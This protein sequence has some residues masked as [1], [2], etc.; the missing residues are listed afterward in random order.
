MDQG[1]MRAT[2][3]LLLSTEESLRIQQSLQ[4]IDAVLAKL[5][6]APGRRRLRH[7]AENQLRSLRWKLE[8]CEARMT[9]SQRTNLAD[10]KA[11]H[12]LS[13]LMVS[14]ISQPGVA[15]L[16]AMRQLIKATLA[17]RAKLLFALRVLQDHYDANEEYSIW[18]CAVL[19]C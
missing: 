3:A 4:D 8:K 13:P 1:R 15:A 9:Y 2:V 5:E 12:F 10:I 6:K 17:E 7:K 18:S 16:A 14:E 11:I 19:A